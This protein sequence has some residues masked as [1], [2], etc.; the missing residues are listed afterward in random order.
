MRSAKDW[1]LWFEKNQGGRITAV[2][3]MAIQDDARGLNDDI[4][5]TDNGIEY[6]WSLDSPAGARFIL[7]PLR[8]H[9]A[10]QV[11]RAK[12]LLR[13]SQDVLSIKVEWQ[14]QQTE[15]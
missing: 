15:H 7:M 10:E 6:T 3:I 8:G 4:E 9:T 11:D 1:Y 5:Y 2:N 13:W 14:N 12:S